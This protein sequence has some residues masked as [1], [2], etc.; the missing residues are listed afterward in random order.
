VWCCSSTVDSID[1]DIDD[2]ID[3]IVLFVAEK[4]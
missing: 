4:D 2:D 3:D 1:D